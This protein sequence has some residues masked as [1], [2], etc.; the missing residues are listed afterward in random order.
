MG[1]EAIYGP[2]RLIWKQ[3][4]LKRFKLGHHINTEEALRPLVFIR[5]LNIGYLISISRA[6][7][8]GGEDLT[9]C[10]KQHAVAEMAGNIFRS[11]ILRQIEATAEMAIDPLHVVL[12]IIQIF[13][14]PLAL[15][16]STDHIDRQLMS[17]CDFGDLDLI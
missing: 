2:R 8:S 6:L 11:Y 17:P 14:L 16:W 12:F 10:N 3:A 4:A 7:S 15:K 1:I 9:M 5:S 13:Q